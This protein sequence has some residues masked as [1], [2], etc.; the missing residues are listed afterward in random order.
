LK[1]FKN[2]N[3]IYKLAMI[4]RGAGAVTVTAAVAAVAAVF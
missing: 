2:T 1:K 4:N 3:K